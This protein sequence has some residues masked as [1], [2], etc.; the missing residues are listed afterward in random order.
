[1]FREQSQDVVAFDKIALF[2]HQKATIEIAVPGYAQLRFFR[3]D[4]PTRHQPI[5]FDHRVRYTV[6]K[7]RVRV[8][9]QLMPGERQ[10]RFQI[11]KRQTRAAVAGIDHD[12]HGL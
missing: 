7:G 1:M 2:I 5:F 9:V 12:V 11:V 10:M 4:R 6:R 8:H 3:Y